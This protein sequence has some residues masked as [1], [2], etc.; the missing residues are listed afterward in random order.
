MEAPMIRLIPRPDASERHSI[1]IDAPRERVW[2][3]LVSL[4]G[5]DIP[6][7]R[8][9]FA[10]RSLVSLLV[11]GRSSMRG[12]FTPLVVEPGRELVLGLIGQWWRLGGSQDVPVESLAQFEAFDR[13]GFAKGTFAFY[14]EDEGGRTRLTTE[15]LVVATSP[16]ALRAFRPYWLIIRPGSGLIRRLILGAVRSR[17]VRP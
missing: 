9:L 17:A 2:E 14:L 13:P 15:T 12:T 11:H 8:A 1:L 6:L 16:D 7:A 4:D 5:R 10:A 3:A